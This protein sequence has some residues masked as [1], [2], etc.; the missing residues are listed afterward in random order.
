SGDEMQTLLHTVVGLGWRED[1][2]QRRLV[3]EAGGNPLF[4]LE[5]LSLLVERGILRREGVDWRP[6]G[7]LQAAL[8]LAPTIREVIE[9]RLHG[10]EPNELQ[11]LAVAAVLGRPFALAD[12]EAACGLDEEQTLAALD[13]LELRRLVTPVIFGKKAGYDYVHPRMQE[14]IYQD[15]SVSRKR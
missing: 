2:L 6:S 7:G 9:A 15:L 5:T 1:A 13:R 3:E 8:P 10:L 12:I 14:V 11:M 4:L